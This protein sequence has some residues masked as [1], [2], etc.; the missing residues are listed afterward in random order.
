MTASRSTAA[1]VVDMAGAAVGEVDAVE[2]VTVGQRRGLGLPGGGP[3]RYV[4]DV[5]RAAAVVTVGSDDD[6]LREGLVV[7]RPSWVDGAVTGEVRVQ[8][9]AHGRTNPATV[10]RRDDGALDVRWHHPQRRIAPG[11]SVVLYDLADQRVLGGGI[12]R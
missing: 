1:R 12:C 2:L 7:D 10:E 5:D 8:C 11:Q 6:L 4:V 3:K 9:S